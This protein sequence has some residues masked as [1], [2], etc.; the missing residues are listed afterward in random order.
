MVMNI[1]VLL[2]NKLLFFP[3][4]YLEKYYKVIVDT[5]LEEFTIVRRLRVIL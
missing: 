1:L 2:N 5:V 4:H 3:S